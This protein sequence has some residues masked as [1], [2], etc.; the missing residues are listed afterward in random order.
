M[1]KIKDE[2]HSF[3]QNLQVPFTKN[4]FVKQSVSVVKA[5]SEILIQ[6]EKNYR[7]SNNPCIFNKTEPLNH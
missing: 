1:A 2:Q 6:N 5:F 7:L 4:A 3:M